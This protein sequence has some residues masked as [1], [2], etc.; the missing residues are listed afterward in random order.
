MFVLIKHIFN[1]QNQFA[2]GG[3]LLMFIG[4]LGVFLR[5]VPEHL[6]SS[7]VQQTTMTVT[8]T[9]DDASFQWVKE[10]FH[11]QHFVTRVRRVNL[12]T[13]LRGAEMALI[14]APGL[15][16]FWYRGRPFWMQFRRSEETKGRS[17]RRVECL[18]FQ[19]LG[20]EPSFLK[21]F[22]S[23]IVA[24][25]HRK[26]MASALYVYDDYWNCVQAYTPRLLESVI[27]KPG[28][29][30]RL[31]QDFE[32]FRASKVRYKQLGV[33]YHR[34][35]LLYGPPGTGKTSLVSGLAAAYGM[36]IYIV[37]LTEMN[38]RSLKVAMNDIPQNSVV[39][40]EDIDCMQV[41]GRRLARKE[42]IEIE[43]NGPDPR[44][45]D[46]VD[47]LGVSLSG[48]LNVLDGV[49]APDSVV[50]VLTT[51]DADAL[52]PALLRP[53]RIDYKLFMGRAAELQKIE[54]YLRFL[55]KATRAEAAH[56]AEAHGAATMAEF[57]GLLLRLEEGTSLALLDDQCSLV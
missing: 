18:T 5:A 36:S 43:A 16:F 51:N 57:Q 15:H 30:E 26:D 38:D 25:H 44:K 42:A 53:G 39:L 10:W 21:D 46:G 41:G 8:V 29:K 52:D 40:F 1:S 47:R 27:L 23:E 13:T 28:E 2:S 31:L 22:V 17:Q 19:T 20:R 54:L 12:D 45:V 9:D 37:N 32:R 3:L 50:F 49:H 14:P 56:F 48:L 24:C 7:L 4:S 35:Y 33:P 34:G 11:E 6:W 55:P